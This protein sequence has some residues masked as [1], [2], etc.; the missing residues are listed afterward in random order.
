MVS[1]KSA[2]WLGGIGFIGEGWLRAVE[3]FVSGARARNSEVLLDA[4]YPPE[5]FREQFPLGWSPR[6]RSDGFKIPTNVFRRDP[7]WAASDLG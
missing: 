3:V 6:L 1:R 2:Y 4:L 7:R 5:Q